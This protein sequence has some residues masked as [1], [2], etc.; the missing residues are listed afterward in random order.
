[1][2]MQPPLTWTG[3]HGFSINGSG[4]HEDTIRIV[5][6]QRQSERMLRLA[7]PTLCITYAELTFQNAVGGLQVNYPASSMYGPAFFDPPVEVTGDDIERLTYIRGAHRVVIGPDETVIEFPSWEDLVVPRLRIDEAKGAPARLAVESA[8]VNVEEPLTITVKQYAD[9]RHVG[10]IAVEARH[11]EYVERKAEPIYDFWLRA[12]DGALQDPMVEATVE[13]WRWDPKASSPSGQG[14]FELVEERYTNSDG[15]VQVGGL[16]AEGLY[17]YT[18]R[19][20]G[21]R[22]APRCIRP[23]A[24]QPVRLHFRAWKMRGDTFRY[25][26]QEHDDLDRLAEFTRVGPEE[27]VRMNRLES[28]RELGAEMQITLPCYDATYRPEG[29]EDLDGVAIRF[30]MRNGDE[31]AVANGLRDGKDY[32][33]ATDLKLPEW[34]FFHAREGDSLAVVDRQFGLPAKS[35][36][37]AH[38]VYRPRTGVLL[39]GEVVAVPSAR[40]AEQLAKGSTRP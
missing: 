39:P 24:G 9:G 34:Q 30:G 11:P 35:S 1:M 36:I 18:L 31:L 37:A 38:R 21:W 32:D 4:L 16:P 14:D 13:I 22:V 6:S 12:I 3:E 28:V 15:V 17:W 5:Q 19:A 29:G 2:T 8:T 40:L 10:G 26:W 23:L 25:K 27:I 33:G 20:V 7:L